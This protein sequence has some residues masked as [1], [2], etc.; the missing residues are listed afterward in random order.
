MKSPTDNQIDIAFLWNKL[1][2][3]FFF[4]I[5]LFALIKFSSLKKK[6]SLKSHL[7]I[8]KCTF[9]CKVFNLDN[10]LVMLI[11]GHPDWP[12]ECQNSVS[13]EGIEVLAGSQ[14]HSAE[15]QGVAVHQRDGWHL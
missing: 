2:P 1:S 15:D 7:H 6:T 4:K 14:D 8:A 11:L 13:R 5:N 10:Q 3:V 9:G 12:D